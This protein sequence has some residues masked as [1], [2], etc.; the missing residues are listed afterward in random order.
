MKIEMHLSESAVKNIILA[1]YAYT[2]SDAGK[3]P[4]KELF[5]VCEYLNMRMLE[6]EST[7]AIGFTFDEGRT[8]KRLLEKDLKNVSSK[9]IAERDV[10][11]RTVLK[12]DILLDGLENQG[13]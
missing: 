8:L 7:I 11:E 12:L 13:E 2:A 10:I 3:K 5:K 6:Q 4:T 9:E 1:L